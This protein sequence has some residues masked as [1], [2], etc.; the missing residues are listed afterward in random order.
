MAVAVVA[1]ELAVGLLYHI[2]GSRARE[3]VA[4][5]LANDAIVLREVGVHPLGGDGGLEEVSG[6]SFQ[7]RVGA[8]RGSDRRR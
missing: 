2:V 3:V 6:E 1:E 5:S 7:A 8:V 4:H